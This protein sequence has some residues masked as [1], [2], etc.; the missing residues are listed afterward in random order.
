[1]AA[2]TGA[3]HLLGLEHSHNRI[4]LDSER[5]GTSGIGVNCFS[6]GGVVFDGGRIV[7]ANEPFSPSRYS[8][9]DRHPPVISRLELSSRWRVTL[10]IPPGSA[11]HGE[12]ELDFFTRQMPL[13]ADESLKSIA[14]A[15]H[16]VAPAILEEDLRALG[17][18]I[19]E[20][21]LI[22]FKKREVER[23]DHSTQSLLRDLQVRREIA[24]GM[25]S[26]GPLVYTITEVDDGHSLEYIRSRAESAGAR[27]V[28]AVPSLTGRRIES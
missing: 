26:L 12:D 5:G 2:A 3:A 17:A 25:S 11:P 15:Y 14:L 19:R 8:K 13:P 18:A 16:G 27:V 21:H 24:A 28:E 7:A 9:P 4:A 22:G 1:L 10:C 6:V 23:Q 20:L